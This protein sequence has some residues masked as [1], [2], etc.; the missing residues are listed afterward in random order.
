MELAL[1]TVQFGMEYGVAG[2][3]AVVPEAEVREILEHA[4]RWGVRLLDTA[5]VYGDIEERLAALIGDADFSIVSKIPA[6]PAGREADPARM[7]TES[8]ERSARRLGPR[9]TTVLFHN[10]DDLLGPHGPALWE[11]ADAVTRSHGIRLGV[12]CYEPRAIA[13]IR[14]RFPIAVAQVPGNALDQRLRDASTVGMLD[15]IEIHLRSVFLQGLLLMPAGPASERVAAAARPLAS[16]HRWCAE[17][18]LPPLRAALSIAKS[19]PGV[20]YCVIGVDRLSQLA[21]IVAAWERA[22]PVS[23]PDLAADALEA[24]DPRRWVV[25]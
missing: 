10:D 7:V 11:A 5:P 16:W 19:L 21:E 3:G 23:A 24:I 22:M 13:P 4:Y 8:V 6:S 1:G 9:L 17:R 20:R 12:S 14:A 2:R 15:G 25:A 18:E